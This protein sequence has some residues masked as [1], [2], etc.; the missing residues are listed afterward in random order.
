MKD[1]LQFASEQRRRNHESYGPQQLASAIR[2]VRKN[3]IIVAED[4][5][6]ESY[7]YRV[8]PDGRSV[9]ETLLHIAA[10]LADRLLRSRQRAH[11]RHRGLRTL[12]HLLKRSAHPREAAVFEGPDHRP[13]PHRGREVGGLRREHPARAGRRARD[14]AE[15]C[16]VEE[17]LRNDA[18]H[19]GA[20]D[21]PPRTA[22]GRRAP[23]RRG[24]APHPQ[25]PAGRGGSP[26]ASS[27][28]AMTST[29]TS[30]YCGWCRT[31]YCWIVGL[32]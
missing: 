9:A 11:L 19:E 16:A 8:T 18:G 20:R 3:T 21:A 25:P 12:R 14:H 28:R 2:T 1:C 17:P 23:P 5:P 26:R 15:R 6:E 27:S 4:I 31:S 22:H 10:A 24:P 13:A 7:G 30:R 32:P 29:G